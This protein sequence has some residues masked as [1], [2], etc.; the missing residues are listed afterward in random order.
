MTPATIVGVDIGG[1]GLRFAVT[2]GSEQTRPILRY[3]EP[4][5]RVSGRIDVSALSARIVTALREGF[6]QADLSQIDAIGIGL[7]GLPGLVEDPQDFARELR[8]HL[9][10]GS[11]VVAGDALTT[12]IGALDSKPG[13]VVAAGTGV[14][15]LGTDLNTIWNRTDGWGILLGDEGSGA[16]IGMRGLQGALRAQDGRMG[17][18]REL[19]RLMTERFPDPSDL[20][21]LV[22]A[23][24][25]TAHH[26]A[27]FAPAVAQAAHL[28][29][30]VAKGIWLE[31]GKLLGQAVSAA[32]INLESRISWGGGLFAAGDLL[33]TPFTAEV[34]RNIPNA[35]LVTPHGG[36]VDGA[37]ALATQA[38]NGNLESREPYLYVFGSTH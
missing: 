1:G 5:P 34:L 23:D 12:H 4:V 10:I 22:R 32:A 6:I 9:R 26:L 11:V 20:V 15:A 36:S 29:D 14:I 27:S 38:A 8:R 18:S 33:L 21:S 19:L 31:A 30:Q 7:T 2:E 17:G 3:D 24:T 28:G 35:A 16:W 13:A 37:C 25:S